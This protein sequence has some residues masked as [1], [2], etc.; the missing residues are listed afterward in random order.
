[1]TDQLKK[2]HQ[3]EGA[4]HFLAGVVFFIGMFRIGCTHW[5]TFPVYSEMLREIILVAVLSIA[6][7]FIGRNSFV[8]MLKEAF[9]EF[10]RN[11]G[12]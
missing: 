10:C 1:M 7:Y 5:G 6:G 12:E 4:G 9:H 2:P 3:F 11:F 8:D